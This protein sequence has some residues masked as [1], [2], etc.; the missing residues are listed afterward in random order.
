VFGLAAVLLV[1]LAGGTWSESPPH[2]ADPAS[3]P[4]AATAQTGQAD[5]VVQMPL[6]A[7]NQV[8]RA[9]APLRQQT[10]SQGPAALLV[11]LLV[12]GMLFSLGFK[13]SRELYRA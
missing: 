1:L 11:I 5:P 3:T 10:P 13:L 6:L 9:N 12:I 4:P 7:A 2:A 8:E